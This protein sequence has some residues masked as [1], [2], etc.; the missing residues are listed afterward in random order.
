MKYRKKPETVE[1]IQFTNPDV[2]KE[3]C[4]DRLRA[5]AMYNNKWHAT[6]LNESGFVERVAVEGDYIIK[7][8]RGHCFPIK[9]WEFEDRYEPEKK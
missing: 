9:T 7:D 5:Y 3:F 8:S 1:A 4:G 2:L 6:I